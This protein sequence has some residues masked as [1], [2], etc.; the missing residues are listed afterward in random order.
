MM[1]GIIKEVF[2]VWGLMF[3]P[4]LDGVTQTSRIQTLDIGVSE[5]E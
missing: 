1:K 5:V 3:F 4:V 2:L